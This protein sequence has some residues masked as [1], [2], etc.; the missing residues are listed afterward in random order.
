MLQ[1][2]NTVL[3]SKKVNLAGTSITAGDLL[4]LNGETGAVI[5][6]SAATIASTGVKSIQFALVKADGTYTKTAPIAKAKIASTTADNQSAYLAKTNATALL[7]F[8]AVIPVIGNR[9]VVRVIYKDLFEHPGQFTHSYEA[10]AKTTDPTD[11][12]TAIKN[13]VNRHAGRRV[14]ATIAGDVVTL[15]AMSVVDNGFGTQGKEAITP[16][17]Q[18]QMR[19]VAYVQNPTNKF[20]SPKEAIS[21]LVITNNDSKPGKGNPY[22]VRDRE[23]AA[24]AYKGITFRTEW[25]IIKPELNVDLTSGYDTF[26]I[27]FSKDYKSPDNQYVK[28]TELAVELYNKTTDTG[29][30]ET[31]GDK[32]RAWMA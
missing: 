1:K 31:L 29:V 18:V 5:D 6:I 20:I 30:L 13:A 21:G 2:P 9:Y 3:V 17:S 26:V 25:P 11:L 10:I 14:N 4:V 28:S 8:S 27:E 32:V 19:P 23:Q 15:T 16:Y 12:A 22:I 7:D 24:L